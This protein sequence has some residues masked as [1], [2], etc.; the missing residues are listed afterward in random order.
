MTNEEYF[1]GLFT[2][3][4]QPDC[5]WHA[6]Q[7]WWECDCGAITPELRAEYAKRRAM[8]EARK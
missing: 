5:N 2:L 6:D 1:K 3:K 7:Y 4:H 8:E